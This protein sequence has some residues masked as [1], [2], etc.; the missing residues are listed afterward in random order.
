MN[1]KSFRHLTIN[2]TRAAIAAALAVGPAIALAALTDLAPSPIAASTSGVVKPN[3]SFVL[4]TSGS[5]AWTHAPDES[6]PFATKYGYKSSQC[7]SIY[8]SPNIS[9]VP[10]KNAD[11]TNFPN[12]VFTA[13]YNDG[14]DT[15][16]GTRNL[17]S[18]FIAYDNTTS[19][20]AGT[21]TAQAAYYYTYSGTQTFN[22]TNTSS[23]FYKECNSSIGSSPGSGVFT[24][25]VV[26]ASSGPGG[27]DERQNFANWFT[28]YRVRIM[29][30]KSGA[31][32][33]FSTIGANYRVGFM[34]IYTTPSNSTTDPGYLSISDYSTTQKTNWFT[35]LYSQDPGGS[36]PL[37]KAL[38]M[39]ARNM[40]G[41][42][43]PDP[44][45][46]S[47][48]QN[49][50]ILTTDGY[51][52]SGT[53]NG[54]KLDGTTSVGNQ[55]GAPMPRPMYDGNVSGSTDTLADVAAYY[56]NTDLRPASPLAGQTP[57]TNPV[58]LADVCADNV[59]VSG[60]DNNPTQ[61]V[62][63]FTLGLGVNGQLVYDSRL[64]REAVRWTTTP[65]WA[66]RRTGPSPWATRSPRSTTSG[67]RRSTGTA[68]TSA[69][70]T[71][72]SWCRACARRLQ[73]C[74]RAKRPVPPR[75]PRTWSR[76]RATTSHTSRTIAPRSGTATSRR[77]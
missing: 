51:W 33:A 9:Y 36:T 40:A 76:S 29:M 27:T 37:K 59:P 11:G 75:R 58:T 13:A 19:F 54:V 43:G 66:A 63:L 48:Q 21:D 16:S 22:Y 46:Y 26:S 5:M 2:V 64:S 39:A 10:P 77:G 55:D 73:A 18:A 50:I 31:G 45:Q 14:Y 42:V 25:V 32:R 47:C 61:H 60:L 62:T 7:N 74:R 53:P 65:S 23:T 6:Q 15:T 4:D 3:V 34:T 30:M 52:N 24:K 49:F 8:Y 20:G 68:S 56:Y 1:A 67:T 70:R 72:T 28:Y 41:L 12:A 35:K 17:S 69:P 38:S 71:R 44:I 57:C